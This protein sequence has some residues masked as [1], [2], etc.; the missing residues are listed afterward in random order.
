MPAIEPHEVIVG[1][2]AEACSGPGW[3]NRLLWVCLRNTHD[4]SYRIAGFQ[5]E[6]QTR[7]MANAFGIC[8]A[9][10][11]FMLYEARVAMSSIKPK[12]KRKKS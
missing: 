7:D 5:P 8:E 3:S 9:A 10:S 4:G 6:E 2:W 11:R 1:A 12:K